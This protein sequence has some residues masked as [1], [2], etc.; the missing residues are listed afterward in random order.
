MS[1]GKIMRRRLRKPTDNQQSMLSLFSLTVLYKVNTSLTKDTLPIGP[2]S[3]TSFEKT[4]MIHTFSMP[5]RR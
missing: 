1:H 2:D 4:Y 3:Y 5:L